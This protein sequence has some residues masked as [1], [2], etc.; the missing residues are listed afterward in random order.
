MDRLL[1]LRRVPLFARLTLDQLEAIN[2][3]ISEAHY[4]DG[5]VICS[6]GDLGDD[7]YVLA[8]GEVDIFR[9]FGTDRQI[10]LGGQSPVSCFGEIAVL[11]NTPRSAT[12]VATRK[13]RLLRLQGTRL[14][15]LVMQM[16]EISFDFFQVLTD[17]VRA[18]DQRF[19]DATR[20]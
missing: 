17:R 2:V 7:L 16:P 11:S 18:A 9:N 20:G 5:E 4:V 8:E 3:I 10:R 1:L 13:A 6:E 15:E 12:V 19:E 14:K